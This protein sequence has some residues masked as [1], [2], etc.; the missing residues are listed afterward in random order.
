[1]NAGA[2]NVDSVTMRMAVSQ[3]RDR[4]RRLGVELVQQNLT[5]V[6]AHKNAST[7]Q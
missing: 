5:G 7:E 1:M 6:Q 2:M 4:L 3:V